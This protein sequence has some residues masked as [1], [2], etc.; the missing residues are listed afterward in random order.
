[1]VGRTPAHQLVVL[2]RVHGVRVRPTAR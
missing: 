1:V 2:P